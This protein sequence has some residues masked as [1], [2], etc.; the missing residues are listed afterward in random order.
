MTDDTGRDRPPQQAPRGGGQVPQPG[1]ITRFL[2]WFILLLLVM[3]WLLRLMGIGVE[4]RIS[5]SEFRQKVAAGEVGLV[6][7][8][9]DRISGELAAEGPQAGDAASDFFVTFLPTFGDDGLLEMLEA[10][11]V[12]VRTEP[13][14][15]SLLP[16]LLFGLLPLVLLLGFGWVLFRRMGSQGGQILSIGKSSARL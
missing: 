16:M 8:K 6:T 3:P 10:N 5:Y 15:G 11:D 4:P 14:D 7:I 1:R 9:G 13:S 2:L 12:E